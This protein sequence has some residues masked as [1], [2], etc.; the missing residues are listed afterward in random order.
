[1]SI[2]G[3]KKYTECKQKEDKTGVKCRRYVPDK[4]GNQRTTAVVEADVNPDGSINTLTHSG[5]EEDIGDL[6]AHVLKY[7]KIKKATGDF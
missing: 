7:A 2:L 1:M 6:T 3:K 5:D 4:D